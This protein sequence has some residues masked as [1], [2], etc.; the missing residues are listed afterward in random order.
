MSKQIART[1][2]SNYIEGRKKDKL[3]NDLR[4]EHEDTIKDH[5]LQTGEHEY[6]LAKAVR[7][8]RIEE[9]VYTNTLLKKEQSRRSLENKRTTSKM[10]DIILSRIV[11]TIS[12]LLSIIFYYIIMSGNTYLML[13]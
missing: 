13:F 3:I 1:N 11:S 12:I 4:E 5:E 10:N 2:S 8:A 6:M 9:R 7:D